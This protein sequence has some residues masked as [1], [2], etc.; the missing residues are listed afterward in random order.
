MIRSANLDPA[1]AATPSQTLPEGAESV[2]IFDTSAATMARR[3]FDATGEKTSPWLA[4]PER[5]SFETVQIVRVGGRLMSRS[6]DEYRWAGQYAPSGV[7]SELVEI[8]AVTS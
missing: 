1:T 4:Y 7:W 5:E 6:R 3:R 8:E 2:R